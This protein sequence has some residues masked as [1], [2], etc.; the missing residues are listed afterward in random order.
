[1]PYIS[2]SSPLPAVTSE[3]VPSLLLRY[4]ACSDRRPRGA[5]SFELISSRSNQPSPSASRN[6]APDPSVS[7]RYFFPVL[8]ALCTNLIFAAA[9]TSVNV[10]GPALH[11]GLPEFRTNDVVSTITMSDRFIVP[12]VEQLRWPERNSMRGQTAPE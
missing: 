12:P 7:G 8:P 11:A 1:M 9:V 4:S 10:A 3:N 5:Q 2:T 6:A